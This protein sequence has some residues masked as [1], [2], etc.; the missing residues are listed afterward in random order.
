M[1]ISNKAI[2]I[3]L[4][5]LIFMPLFCGEAQQR[6]SMASHHVDLIIAP[7]DALTRTSG[8]DD[9]KVYRS[10][11]DILKSQGFVIDEKSGVTLSVT[12]SSLPQTD[13][14]FYP[15]KVEV[16]GGTRPAMLVD[17]ADAF[18]SI[19]DIPGFKNVRGSMNT[20]WEV[21]AGV[22]EVVATVASKLKWEMDRVSAR[23]K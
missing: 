6:S 8:L 18:Q 2:L 5:M 22:R 9:D 15:F 7:F 3:L 16:H 13:E 23:S 19:G 11:A 21:I 17:E 20:D 12:I 14:D 4:A 1:I 10:A